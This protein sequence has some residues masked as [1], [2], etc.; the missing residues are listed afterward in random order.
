MSK[1][2]SLAELDNKAFRRWRD[3]LPPDLPATPA[4]LANQL[5]KLLKATTSP[6]EALQLAELC[7]DLSYP[8][9]AAKKAAYRNPVRDDDILE[10]LA[11]TL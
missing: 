6:K 5:W 11:G 8:S 7:R 4:A 2:W 10:K 3:G 1:H 9:K